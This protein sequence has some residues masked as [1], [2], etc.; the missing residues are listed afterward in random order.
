MKKSLLV[1]ITLGL[2]LSIIGPTSVF[3][4]TKNSLGDTISN[5]VTD[6]DNAIYEDHY[7][8]SLRDV[9]IKVQNENLNITT[10][11]NNA[12]S[13]KSSNELNDMLKNKSFQKDLKDEIK[14][15]KKPIAIGVAKAEY[16][17]TVDSN[18]NVISSRPMTNKEVRESTIP[19]ESEVN[20]KPLSTLNFTNKLSYKSATTQSW[21]PLLA[22][23]LALN[24]TKQYREGLE[25]FTSIS[26]TSPTY[27]VQANA[28]WSG[29]ESGLGNEGIGLTW[30]SAFLPDNNNKASITY[31]LGT[32]VAGMDTFDPEKGVS[33]SFHDGIN[34][35]LAVNRLL[36]AYAGISLTRVSGPV[37]KHS[38]TASYI[39]T[40][41][42]YPWTATISADSTKQTGVAITVSPQKDSW[43]LVSYVADNF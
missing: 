26:G 13:I 34:S 7:T 19:Y 1:L 22:N 3:A 39:H 41:Q 15:G 5:T 38:F 31:D 18:G 40:Y 11:K 28:Y 35:G 25:L 12:T 36:G 20:T 2:T 23:K 42:D 10:T 8:L 33:W 37:A 27:W 32:G 21:Q 16:I 29:T 14:N 30:Q 6:T 17:K 43:V 9:D 24:G 4:S